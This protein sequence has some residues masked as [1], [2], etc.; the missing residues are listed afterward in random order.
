MAA[1]A[2]GAARGRRRSGAGSRSSAS[3]RP[4]PSGRSASSSGRSQDGPLPRPQL[5]ERL[6]AA[7]S[8]RRASACRTC[9]ALAAAR[10]LIVLGVC[11]ERLRAG[12]RLARRRPAPPPDRDAAL[13]ELARRYLRGHGPATAADLATW[14]GLGL[15]AARAGLAAIAGE[16]AAGRRAASTWRTRDAPGAAR[17]R[18]CC[19]RSTPTCWAG[20]T[21]G[22][23]SRPSTRGGSTRAA[24]S[25]A[26]RRWRTAASSATWTAPGGKVGLEPFA[27]LDPEDAA[28]LGRGRRRG[29]VQRAVTRIRGRAL[30]T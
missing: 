1:R 20:R 7:G 15:R 22:S 2:D 27:P 18:A 24:G 6:R 19:R 29:G 17:R 14:S 10:G 23:R 9:S 4:R 28:A 3:A 21:A 30:L 26:R 8:P 16:L 25:C 11:G 12:A 5:G 13:A